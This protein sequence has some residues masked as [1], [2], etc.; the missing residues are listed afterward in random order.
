V[1]RSAI[2]W[3][4]LLP[5]VIVLLASLLL[6]GHVLAVQETIC[7]RVDA[8]T[9]DEATVDGHEIPLDGLDADAVAGLQLALNGN[10]DACVEVETDAGVVTQ[11]YS[12]TVTADL[13][14][15]VRPAGGT[16][17]MVDG[18]VIP[19]ELVNAET[20]TALQFA[21]S[22]NG[23]ACLAIDVAGDGSTT[24]VEVQFDMEACGT[25]T[26][27]GNGT[28]ELNG[29]TFDVAAGVDLEADVDDVIC[30]FMT[31]SADGGVEITQRTDE[32]EDGDGGGE[33]DGGGGQPVPDTAMPLAPSSATL[34]AG[35]L[36]V[37]TALLLGRRTTRHRP[38]PT[39]SGQRSS[40]AGSNG[41]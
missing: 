19:P 37:G 32:D 39:A 22:N 12:V 30:V 10:L 16:D 21:M 6:A 2:S 20:M 26:A 27:V 33:V 31:T 8:V 3:R 15:R 34:G 1:A 24:T 41:R 4:T 17:V 14:G 25:V 29:V 18:V 28:I 5:P 13:C 38:T 7:G 40:L 36:L 35:L 9:Q 23:S 11:A